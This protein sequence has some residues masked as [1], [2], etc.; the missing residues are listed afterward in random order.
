MGGDRYEGQ[1][2]NEVFEG[3]GSYIQQS[4]QKNINH[5]VAK[6]ITILE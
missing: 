5:T 6:D 3:V 2:K 1:W 4:D